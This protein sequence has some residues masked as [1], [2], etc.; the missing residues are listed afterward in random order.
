MSQGHPVSPFESASVPDAY[1]QF[2]QPVIFEP[3]AARLLEYVGLEPGQTVLDVA[4]GTGV[5]ARA[6]A[7]A[8]GPTGKVIASDLSPAMLAHVMTGLDPR[9]APVETLACSATDLAVP[10]ASIDVALC[11][12][13]F[14]F[15]PDRAAA[16]R[17]MLRVLR[18]GGRMGAAVWLSGRR[19]EPFDTYADALREE[20]V[21]SP[22]PH[23]YESARM[24][25]SGEEVQQA[26][27]AGGFVDIEV[28][29]L[30]LELA[31]P[32][33]EAAARG[34]LGTPYGPALAAL[35]AP[36]QE[37]LQADLVARMTNPH[38]TAVRHLTVAVLG[39]GTAA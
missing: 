31:W 23:A 8:V 9:G 2:L 13:G 27:A 28:D 18:A 38:G 20:G 32:S 37:R 26:L 6:A 15:I 1:R 12:Q 25:M 30:E 4:S 33:P 24:S 29:T 35:D 36:R 5:V 16:A 14:P 11:Q 22:F 21:E 17:E 34:I 39:R 7:T 10:D 19:L 3:W